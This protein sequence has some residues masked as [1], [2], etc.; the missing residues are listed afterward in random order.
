MHLRY[1]LQPSFLES[2]LEIL[3][4]SYDF[5]LKIVKTF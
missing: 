5:D 4:K 1:K 3:Y 2:N